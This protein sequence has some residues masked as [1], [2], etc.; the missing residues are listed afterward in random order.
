MG[1]Q[2]TTTPRNW[3]LKIATQKLRRKKFIAP[4]KNKL[5]IELLWT[6]N[7]LIGN[8]EWRT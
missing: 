6:R 4:G 7:S 2:E 1:R 3:R 8:K 5:N